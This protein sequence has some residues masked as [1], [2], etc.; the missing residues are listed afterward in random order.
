M[1][2]QVEQLIQKEAA[3][4]LL[5][6]GIS[7]PLSEI[8]IPMLKKPVQLRVTMKRPTLASL[9]RI[10][11]IYLDMGVTSRQMRDFDKEQQMRF[12]AE[13]GRDV[14]LMVA[15]TVC[16]GMISRLLARPLA[17]YIRHCMEYRYLMAAILQFTALMGTKAF[18]PIIASVERMNPLKLRK[19]HEREGS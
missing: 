11:R 12:L 14:S 19:S 15:L 4:A 9:M 10:A 3:E 18:T 2:E 17:W 5:D 13:H 1:E 16:R 7:L 6:I 8:R